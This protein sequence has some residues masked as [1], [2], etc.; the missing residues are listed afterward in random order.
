MNRRRPDLF[1]HS[2]SS[3]APTGT[4]AAAVVVR[5]D[6]PLGERKRTKERMGKGIEKERKWEPTGLGPAELSL[7]WP[8]PRLPLWPRERKGKKEMGL[9]FVTRSATWFL[10]PPETTPCRPIGSSG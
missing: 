5:S 3:L 2:S 1:Q 9:G 8:P 10:V 6:A 4:A 7:P